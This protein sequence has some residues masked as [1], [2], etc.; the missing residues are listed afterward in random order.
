MPRVGQ[1]GGKTLL[2]PLD[3]L[4]RDARGGLRPVLQ[5]RA[6]LEQEGAEALAFGCARLLQCGQR[7]ACGA[8]QRRAELL[9]VDAGGSLAGGQSPQLADRQRQQVR[10]AR[11]Q[12][13]FGLQHLLDR[14]RVGLQ[15]RGMGLLEGDAALDLATAQRAAEQRAQRRLGRARLVGQAQ[16]Q[17]E[18]STVDAAQLDAHRQRRLRAVDRGGGFGVTGHAIK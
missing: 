3:R 18:E 6:A 9:C 16:H 13:S 12:R 10:R 17:V 15:R 5:L 8:L 14:R 2:Q 1:A 7:G 4:R 11:A